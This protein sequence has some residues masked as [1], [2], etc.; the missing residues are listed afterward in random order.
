M[1][2]EEKRIYPRTKIEWPVSCITSGGTIEGV[3]ENINMQGAF[4]CCD[5]PLSPDETLL[6]TIKGPSGAMQVIAKVVW[7]HT[8]DVEYNTKP[9][10]MGVKFIWQR[11]T[12]RIHAPAQRS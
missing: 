1:N 3:T 10:G 6:L 11:L 2:S 4:I 9:K 7:S 12:P 8:A 5:E